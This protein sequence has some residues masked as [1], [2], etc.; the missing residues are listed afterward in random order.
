MRKKLNQKHKK[1]GI[2]SVPNIKQ[3]LMKQDFLNERKEGDII[4]TIIVLL[5]V[6]RTWNAGTENHINS[7][8]AHEPGQNE[9][10]LKLMQNSAF[11][12]NFE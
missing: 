12:S 11:F 2:K 4:H 3:A 6:M 9:P 5:Q 1:K 10:I 7:K 8:T